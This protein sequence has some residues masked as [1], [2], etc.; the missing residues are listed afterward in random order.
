MNINF[1]TFWEDYVIGDDVK[2]PY[3]ESVMRKLYLS[4]TAQTDQ[5]FNQLIDSLDM[6]GMKL[7]LSLNPTG[8]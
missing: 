8:Q 4:G 3:V 1:S 7:N 2:T 6:S 5:I